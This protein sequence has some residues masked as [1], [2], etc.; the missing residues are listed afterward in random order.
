MDIDELRHREVDGIAFE[1]LFFFAHRP[2]PNGRIGTTCLSQWW[3]APFEVGGEVYATAEHYAMVSKAR[4]FGDEAIAQYILQSTAPEE[5][6][7]LGREVRGFQ[8]NAWLDARYGIVVAANMEKFTRRPELGLYLTQHTGRKI[9]AHANP[10][11][12]LW[13]IGLAANDIRARKPSEWRGMNWLGFALMEVREKLR[14]QALAKD[15][16]PL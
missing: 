10:N 7:E 16:N 8:Q 4:L 15:K 14:L 5:A 12:Q 6:I 13:G 1:L 3:A 11:D 9:L 2:L